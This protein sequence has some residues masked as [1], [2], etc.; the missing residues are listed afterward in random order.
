MTKFT[1]SL[2]IDEEDDQMRGIPTIVKVQYDL[3]W[4]RIKVFKNM[5]RFKF[6]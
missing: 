3:G 6:K 4:I 1:Y 5:I 2:E